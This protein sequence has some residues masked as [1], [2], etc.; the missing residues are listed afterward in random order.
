M[1][2]GY[3]W[4]P[5]ALTISFFLVF[6]GRFVT[7][8]K[9]TSSRTIGLLYNPDKPA[10][11]P[12]WQRLKTWLTG[13][14]FKVVASTSTTLAMKNAELIIAVGGDGTVLKTARAVSSWGTP[15]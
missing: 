2:R 7:M 10:T 3:R 15:I 5:L 11:R 12:V 13:K 14:G 6:S 1:C 9:P 4:K 8:S